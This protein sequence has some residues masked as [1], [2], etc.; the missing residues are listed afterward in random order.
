M[1]PIE[2]IKG[3]SLKERIKFDIEYRKL[4]KSEKKKILSDR[5]KIKK[6]LLSIKNKDNSQFFSKDYLDKII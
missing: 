4:L 5:R 6:D 2:I 3:L 1:E